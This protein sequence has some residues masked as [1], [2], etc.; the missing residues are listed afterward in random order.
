M[1]ILVLILSAAFAGCGA[2]PPAAPAASP[3]AQPQ[4]AAPA[5]TA[6]PAA[7][8]AEAVPA[9]PAPAETAAAPAVPQAPARDP[10]WAQPV[11][12]PGLPN[13][14]KVSDTLYRGAQ[15][16]AEGFKELKAMGIKT[17]VNLRSFHSDS[18]EIG[19]LGL[20]CEHIY[21][22]AWHAENED[23]VR[24]LTIVSDPAR[25]PVFVHCQ[26]GADRTGTM[27]AIYRIVL[28]GWTREEAI[29]EMTEGGFGFHEVWDN[30]PE[31]IGTLDLDGIRKRAG[32]TAP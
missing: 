6:A 13:L 29:R 28:Q 27:C 17:V 23:V 12:K 9:A 2:V 31:Y 24:F 7:P 18:D 32:I 30:L 11:T 21:M 16:T 4:A 19:D 20:P 22:K 3:A 26:H 8:P 14:H 1:L 10:R 5:G 25:Q 15:P